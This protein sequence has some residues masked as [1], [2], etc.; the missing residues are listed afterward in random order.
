MTGQL[1]LERLGCGGKIAYVVFL[2]CVAMAV[3]TPAQTFHTLASFN[4]TNGSGPAAAL[5]QGWDGNFYGTTVNGGTNNAGTVFRVTRTG[6][7]A[8]LYSFCGQP[9]C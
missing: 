6:K 3:T 5:V 1:S 8:T 9:A 2:V 4:G 7:L